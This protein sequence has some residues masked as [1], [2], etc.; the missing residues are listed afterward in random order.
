MGGMDWLAVTSIMSS[1]HKDALL[2]V[3]RQSLIENKKTVALEA[4]TLP[5]RSIAKRKLKQIR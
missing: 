4:K 1:S 5:V 2:S 3:Y